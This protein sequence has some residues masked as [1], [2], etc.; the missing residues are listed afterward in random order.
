M[1]DR[2]PYLPALDGLRAIAVTAVLLYHLDLPWATGGFLGVDL[3]FVISGFLI[4]TLLLGEHATTGRIGI[5]DFWVRRFKRLVPPLVVM[6]AAT[7]GATRLWGLPEQWTSVR[8]DAAAALGYVANWRFVLAEQSY[9]ETLLGPSPLLHTWSLAVEEQWYVVW[10]LVMVGLAAVAAR[11]R[12]GGWW[13]LAL[14]GAAAVASAVWMAVLYVASDPSRVYYGTDTRA[15]QLLVGAA[16]AW[17]V[18]LRPR[19]SGIAER[20]SG[21]LAVTAALG[22][23]AVLVSVTSDSA[24]R[25]YHGGFLAISVLCAVLV[26]GTATTSVAS[27]L[28]WLTSRPALWIGLRSYSIY[29]WHWP[30]IVFVGPP[31][32]VELPRVPLV[33]LQVLV[34][35]ALADASHRLV[36]RPTRHSGWRPVAVV[37]GWS[38]AGLAAI[39]VSLFLLQ[40]SPTAFSTATVFRPAALSSAFDEE[41][42][43]EPS[44]FSESPTP[45][46][47]PD[48]SDEPMSGSDPAAPLEERTD[49]VPRQALLLGDSTAAALWDR[50]SPAWSA[51]WDVQLMARLGCG[52]FDG[53]TLDSDSDRGNPNPAACSNWREDWA[54]S[55]TIDP[56]VVVVMVGSWEMLDHRVDGIDYRFPSDAWY[57]LVSSGIDDAIGIAASTGSPVVVLSLPCMEPSGDEDTTA[58]TDP[59]RLAAVNDMFAASAAGRPGVVVADLGS[60][61]CPDGQ[62]I[63]NVDGEPARYDGVHVSAAGSDHVWRWLF[64]QLEGLT[65]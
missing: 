50:M 10:P 33:L 49:D 53:V 51:Q 64:P 12:R 32:G 36:E 14:I 54:L 29:L 7:I 38:S 62:P 42:P 47:I 9:F 57:Q 46:R 28:R 21:A 30:V 44:R 58:R 16:L 13:V 19:L 63:G 5:R 3:F 35:L 39:V 27:P 61:L 15:Q 26:V 6:T 18:R 11:S 8:W 4:T 22:L 20:T 55:M 1:T 17:L 59:A 34:T 45:E 56:D 41:S 23:F 25:L 60:V 52:V 65:D 31:M 43:T 48:F 37:G 24:S 2:L 40:P